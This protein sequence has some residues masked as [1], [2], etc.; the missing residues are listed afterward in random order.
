[1]EE[2]IFAMISSY[3]ECWNCASEKSQCPTCEDTSNFTRKCTC[4]SGEHWATCPAP[5]GWSECG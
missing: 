5:N 3:H 2:V 1:M 4:G